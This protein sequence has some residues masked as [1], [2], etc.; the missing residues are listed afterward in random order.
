LFA[1][2]R[3]NHQL[4]AAILDVEHRISRVPLRIYD[5]SV[6]V[7]PSR[8]LSADPSEEV[9]GIESE[10]MSAQANCL[11]RPDLAPGRVTLVSASRT[12]RESPYAGSELSIKNGT[13]ASQ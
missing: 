7:L 13:R 2:R 6:L 1:A 8:L 12:G 4:H 11:Q 3:C 10:R 5:L 9:P